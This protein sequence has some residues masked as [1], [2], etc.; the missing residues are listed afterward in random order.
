VPRKTFFSDTA[1]QPTSHT[2]TAMSGHGDQGASVGRRS[3]NDNI[4]GAALF[5]AAADLPV[6]KRSRQ[7]FEILCAV[8]YSFSN[9]RPCI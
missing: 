3:G 7:S 6:A 2:R 8:S 1:Q 4:F 9:Q 5:H